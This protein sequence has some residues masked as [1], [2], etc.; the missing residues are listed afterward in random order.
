[1]EKHLTAYAPNT[2]KSMRK[3]YEGGQVIHFH[4]LKGGSGGIQRQGES[5]SGKSEQEPTSMLREAEQKPPTHKVLLKH[6]EQKCSEFSSSKLFKTRIGDLL[7]KK[8]QSNDL[9]L[10][11]LSQQS[12]H[13]NLGQ[14]QAPQQHHCCK[15]TMATSHR[16]RV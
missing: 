13:H 3:T 6:V 16:W 4:V 2:Q 1:M 10:R 5:C 11:H 14:Q 12:I 15:P 9:Q 7:W 8:E